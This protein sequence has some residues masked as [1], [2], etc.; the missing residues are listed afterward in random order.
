MLLSSFEGVINARNV[1]LGATLGV[2]LRV[3]LGAF[4]CNF[5]YLVPTTRL[6]PEKVF[7]YSNTC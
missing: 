4:W 1:I 5:G 7:T 6:C 2:I 3:I